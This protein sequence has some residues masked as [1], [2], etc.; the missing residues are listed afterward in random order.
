M[1][2][3]HKKN[4]KFTQIDKVAKW[5]NIKYYNI[6]EHKQNAQQNRFNITLE[7]NRNIY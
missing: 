4:N 6:G 2:N 1:P 7:A 3:Q 5:I